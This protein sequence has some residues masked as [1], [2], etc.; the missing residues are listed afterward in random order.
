[1]VISGEAKPNADADIRLRG[2][3]RKSTESQDGAKEQ[4]RFHLHGKFSLNGICNRHLSR[5]F[6]IRSIAAA[7]RTTDGR[8]S[9]CQFLARDE[10]TG[11]NL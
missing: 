8:I 9:K 3:P 11:Q 4:S 1:M 6:I 7:D 5:Q 2:G 10:L